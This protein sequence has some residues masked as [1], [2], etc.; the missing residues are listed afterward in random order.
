MNPKC[1]EAR[2]RDDNPFEGMLI[3]SAEEVEKLSTRSTC[4]R[5]GKS[6]MYFCYTCFVPVSS[7][8]GRIPVCRVSSQKRDSTSC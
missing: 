3:A 1:P 8:E 7:L 6:R 2:N 4:P 5:C